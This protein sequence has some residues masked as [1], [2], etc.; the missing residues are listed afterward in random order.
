MIH[1][2][3]SVF[4]LAT[5]IGAMSVILRIDQFADT[6]RNGFVFHLSL[7]KIETV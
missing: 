4:N 1:L 5:A 6:L 2:H 3:L 7:L